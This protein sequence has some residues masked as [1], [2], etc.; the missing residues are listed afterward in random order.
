MGWAEDLVKELGRKLEEL[1]EA[2]D[3]LVRPPS[4]EELVPVPVPVPAS[5][6]RKGGERRRPP[7]RR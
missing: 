1:R 7:R 3:Q 6:G 2:L 5:G 4:D